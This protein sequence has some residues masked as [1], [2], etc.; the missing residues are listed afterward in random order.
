MLDFL[1]KTESCKKTDVD[2]AQ[3]MIREGTYLPKDVTLD[4]AMPI[5]EKVNCPFI[6][7]VEAKLFDE[8]PKLIGLIYH[9]DSLKEFNKALSSRAEEEHS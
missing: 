1:I 4:E 7:I 2:L 3:V 6:P 9:N 5:F 8:G